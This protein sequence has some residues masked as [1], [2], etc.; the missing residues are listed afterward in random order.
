MLQHSQNLYAL[1]FIARK[2]LLYKYLAM[3]SNDSLITKH[4]VQVNFIN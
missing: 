3:T 1:I 4:F 2:I